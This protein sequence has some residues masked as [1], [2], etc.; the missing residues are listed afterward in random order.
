[1]L[2]FLP[3]HSQMHQG[4]R[5]GNLA[6]LLVV[7]VIRYRRTGGDGAHAIDHTGARQHGFAEHGF[8]RGSVPDNC[9]VPDIGRFVLFHKKELEREIVKT[10]M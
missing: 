2:N 1:M 3:S 8:S 10:L 5:N 7:V 4:G 6:R 9:K